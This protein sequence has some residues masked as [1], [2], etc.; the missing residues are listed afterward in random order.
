ME[1]SNLKKNFKEKKNQIKK[2]K[3]CSIF[4][5]LW[6]IFCQF[7]PKYTKLLSQIVATI[8]QK[9]NKNINCNSAYGQQWFKMLH[10]SIL[11][12][13]RNYIHCQR[14]F[15]SKGEGNTEIPGLWTQELD[16][17]LSTLDS[18]YWTLDAALWTLDSGCWTLDTGVW[19]LDSVRFSDYPNNHIRTPRSRRWIW[20]YLFPSHLLV[21]QI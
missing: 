5:L 3:H 19:T 12:R 18:G 16:A 2:L 14:Y 8:K 6:T 13:W 11:N 4:V 10:I 17:G 15:K 1:R 20:T 21:L 9:L 7:K